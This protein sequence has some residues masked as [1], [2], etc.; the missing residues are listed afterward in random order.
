LLATCLPCQGITLEP[1]GEREFVLDRAELLSADEVLEIRAICDKLLTEHATPI[2]VVTIESMAEYY[3][4]TVS[5]ESFATRLF[6]QW[7]IGHATL[8]NAEWNTGILLLVSRDDRRARIELGGGWAHAKDLECQG[9]MDERILPMF[10]AGSFAAG[11]RA[12]V[13]ALD[14]LARSKPL[15]AI[16]QPP[17]PFWH[18]LVLIGAIGLAI[19]TA[20]SLHRRGSSGWAWLMW[21]ALFTVIGVVIYQLMSN[22]NSGGGFGGGS[23]GGGSSGG[24]GASGSW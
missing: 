21:G 9:I 22:R 12:G 3:G 8:N 11:I 16:E 20:V 1:P 2:L 15:P 14:A 18:W 4:R 7:Q 19:F 24:G 13:E 10:K 23:F 5:I 17:R 6:N